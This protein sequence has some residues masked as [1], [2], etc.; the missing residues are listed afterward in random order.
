M[1][2]M[3][4][5]I[6]ILMIMTMIMTMIMIMI[7][8]ITMSAREALTCRRQ[9]LAPAEGRRGACPGSHHL[10]QIVRACVSACACVCVC[11]RARVCVGYIKNACRIH[12]QHFF[13]PLTGSNWLPV[14]GMKKYPHFPN[15]GISVVV[16]W[17]WW[18]WWGKD[19][20]LT[21]SNPVGIE[22]APRQ[23]LLYIIFII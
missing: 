3:I 20:K 12:L 7:M 8:I 1:I 10:T 2:I 6:M 18:W 23:L 16:W 13:I 5:M 11:A 4:L 21:A 17:W 15:G 9:E 14:K 22:L 19:D